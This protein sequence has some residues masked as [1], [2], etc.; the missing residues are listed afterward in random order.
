[1]AY[2]PALNEGFAKCAAALL[3][4]RAAALRRHQEQQEHEQREQQQEHERDQQGHEKQGPG[5]ADGGCGAVLEAVPRLVVAMERRY[6]FSL[7]A[8]AATAPAAD[9]FMTY[10][11]VGGREQPGEGAA[12]GAEQAWQQQQHHQDQQ[13]QPRQHQEQP[14][15]PEQ[16]QDQQPEQQQQQVG[17][18]RP[19]RRTPLFTGRR[20][21]LERVPQARTGFGLDGL[22][23]INGMCS[24]WHSWGFGSWQCWGPG[25]TG[26]CS[27]RLRRVGE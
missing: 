22:C 7:S 23:G 12:E 11:R 5:G 10:V 14:Q 13:Q 21:P 8:L 2:D 25:C 17:P 18:G 16:Q 6:V 27:S 1:M 26:S 24:S 19:S 3:E 9:D 4:V 15:Q 20:L